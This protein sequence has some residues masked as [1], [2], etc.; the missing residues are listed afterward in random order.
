MSMT[1]LLLALSGAFG[2]ACVTPPP[3]SLATPATTTELLIAA[4]TDVHGRLRGWDYYADAPDTLYSLARAAT[5]V[6]SLRAAHPGAVL[7]VDAGDLLQGNPLAYVA[8]RVSADT[9]HP[10]IAAMN[11]MDYDAAAVGNHEFNYGLAMFNRAVRQATFPFLAANAYTPRGQRAYP[12]HQLVERGGVLIGIVGATTPGAMIWD[13][14]NLRGRLELRDIVPDVRAA[15]RQVRALGAD[16]VVVTLHSGLTGASSYDTAS[17]GIASENVSARVAREVGG[18]D[19]LVFGHSHREVVDTIIGGTLLIQPRNWAR[20]VAVARVRLERVGEAWRVTSRRG[21]AIPTPGRAE[22]PA[23]LAASESV[24]RETKS[25]VTAPIG[26]TPV[27]WRGDSA[28]VADT[29]LIDFVLEVQRRA[30]GADLASTAAFS[31]E[32]SLDSGEVT[33]ADLARLYPYDNTLRAVRISGAQLREYLEYSARYFRTLGTPGSIV[34]P[35][36]PG[37]NFDIVSGV[38]YA[39]DLSLPAGSRIVHLARDGQPVVPTDSFTLALNNYRQTGGGGYSMLA[40]APLVYDEGTDIRQ[41][42]IEEVRRRGTIRPVDYFTANWSLGPPAA[43]HAA[44]EAMHR[45]GRA[46]AT[47]DTIEKAKP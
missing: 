18:I 26:L 30:A 42:L 25:Y 29:P 7:L 23:V 38:D 33:I 44:Y 8:A 36:V 32:A 1:R 17:T 19:V 6:D 2:V 3:P 39:I 9:L 5:V 22:H 41:L 37:Y 4:T 13:R 45:H 43:A 12:A 10:V 21:E 31:L 34:D 14:D 46:M 47:S 11:V 27:S 16:I 28:R 24:H 15:V 35:E 20:S 40:G